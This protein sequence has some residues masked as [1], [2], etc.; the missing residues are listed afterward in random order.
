MRNILLICAIFALG[1]CE[2]KNSTLLFPPFKHTW[3]VHRGTEEKLDMLT[4]NITDF[5]DP[6]GLASIKLNSWDDPKKEEDDCEITAFGVNSGKGQIIYNSTMYSL[7]VYGTVGSG[8]GQMLHPHGICATHDGNVYI[9][10]TGNRRIVHLRIPRNELK[11]VSAFGSDSL[12]EPFDIKVTTGDTLYIS[13]TKRNSIVVMDSTGKF[14]REYK[15]LIAPRGL[16]VDDPRYRWSA[17]KENFIAV[18]DSNG[19][20]IVKLDRSKGTVNKTVRMSSF[21][22]TNANLQYCAIDYLDNIYVTDFDRCQIHKFD[23]ELTFLTSFGSCGTKDEQFQNP[24]G[25]AIYRKFGQILIAE[26]NAAQYFWVGVDVRD[27]KLVF[28]PS[29]RKLDVSAFLTEEAYFT[30][31]IE[32][33]D[34]Q[35][36]LGKKMRIKSGKQTVSLEI[37][38]EIPSGKYKVK[39]TF[40][41]TYSS[42][43]Q[44]KKE[45]DEKVKF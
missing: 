10:D 15:K 25:I 12:L 8:V 1:Y 24:R 16:A 43:G 35:R 38:A 21:G 17:Y 42:M 41:P 44:F 9:A 39:I 13:D 31:Q 4:G 3:G 26:R 20:R 18:I 6:Q 19:K 23:K 27:L 36:V 5:D 45:F 37:P 22:A 2:Q 30:A 14:I 11:W 28:D 34:K 32:Y 7:S 29:T 33:K 40:E